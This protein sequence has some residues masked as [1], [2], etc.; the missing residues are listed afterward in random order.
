M[1]KIYVSGEL[2]FFAKTGIQPRLKKTVSGVSG[3]TGF[4]SKLSL[5]L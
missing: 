1:G 4:F 5:R 3:C 2:T